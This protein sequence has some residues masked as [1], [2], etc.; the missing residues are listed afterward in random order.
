MLRELKNME[1]I[2]LGQGV[3]LH[4]VK[5]LMENSSIHI[6]GEA[7][8][9]DELKFFFSEARSNSYVVCCFL[10]EEEKEA[11]LQALKYCHQEKM[12]FLH[13]SFILRNC[14]FPLSKAPKIRTYGF[15]G[16]GNV[17]LQDF[18]FTHMPSTIQ[19][20]LE[21]IYSYVG[22][23]YANLLSDLTHD[24]CK[25]Y[26][27]CYFS[28]DSLKIFTI[29]E[30][31]RGSFTISDERGEYLFMLDNFPYPA[32]S[33]STLVSDHGFLHQSV[34][35]FYNNKRFKQVF[36]ARHPFDA[37]FS[38]IKKANML[39]N[40]NKYEVIEIFSRY[41]EKYMTKVIENQD[42]VFT[43][44]YENVLY[45]TINELNKFSKYCQLNVTEENIMEWKKR[46][47]FT[48]LPGAPNAYHFQGGGLGKWKNYI[49]ST[50]LEIFE[51]NNIFKI[52][53]N[54]DY[55]VYDLPLRSSANLNYNKKMLPKTSRKIENKLYPGWGIYDAYIPIKTP[56]EKTIYYMARKDF[57]FKEKE[58]R[59][60][61]LPLQLLI[62]SFYAE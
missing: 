12:P 54:L 35:D 40:N 27:D 47:L 5:Y 20:Q 11:F 32:F 62:D 44:K 22:S 9:L 8:S 57:Q 4:Q 60:S 48:S 41:Y 21:M 26:V 58:F 36:I 29:S 39:E 30:D 46:K 52:M 55:E 10:G 25:K 56:K 53:K 14:E 33:W 34:I 43:I 13:P 50:C 16:S 18:I 28:L 38:Y 6:A 51:K 49:D 15:P 42:Y 19:S 24:L 61:L 1:V 3:H 59:N 37:I 31:Y 7:S 45:D 2:L 17:L 23:H